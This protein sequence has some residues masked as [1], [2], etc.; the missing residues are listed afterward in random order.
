MKGKESWGKAIRLEAEMYHGTM[1]AQEGLFRRA[2]DRLGSEEKARGWI[3]TPNRG[4][5][6]R[7]PCEVDLVE[8]TDVLTRIEYG[9]FG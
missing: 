9:V 8:A 2:T 7:R 6:G 3:A 5:G 4:R 1:D